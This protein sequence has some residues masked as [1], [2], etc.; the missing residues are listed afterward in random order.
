MPE[1]VENWDWTSK[2]GV[3]QWSLQPVHLGA[4]F[5][6]RA[7]WAYIY[8]LIS[9]PPCSG[10]YD[11]KGL[12]LRAPSTYCLVSPAAKNRDVMTAVPNRTCVTVLGT[13][14]SQIVIDSPKPT[15]WKRALFLSSHFIDK[16]RKAHVE[17]K[18]HCTYKPPLTFLI[19]I[20]I[21]HIFVTNNFPCFTFYWDKW[22]TQINYLKYDMIQVL[23]VW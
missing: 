1:A 17:V 23:D 16:E 9:L 4:N 5:P 15:S 12:Y 6:L 14:F 20:C 22:I 19:F 2:T 21:F 18:T 10:I 8:F 7:L 3:L 13:K 11:I